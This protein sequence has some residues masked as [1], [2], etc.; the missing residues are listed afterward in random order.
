M[1]KYILG[2][3]TKQAKMICE[4]LGL[5]S[6][7]LS[8]L[9]RYQPRKKDLPIFISAGGAFHG[10]SLIL[11]EKLHQAGREVEVKVIYDRH[12]DFNAVVKEL[13]KNVSPH[14]MLSSHYDSKKGK[15][16]SILVPT[17]KEI[18]PKNPAAE[19]LYKSYGEYST[20]ALSV[21]QMN[22][23]EQL[24]LLGIEEESQQAQIDFALKG[25]KSILGK[26]KAVRSSTG[27]VASADLNRA[28]EIRNKKVHISIDIDVIK[29]VQCVGQN[30]NGETGPSLEE[31]VNS[32]ENLVS[33][34]IL[35][36]VDLVGYYPTDLWNKKEGSDTE[37]LNIYRKLLEMIDP[38]M[39]VTEEKLV[40]NLS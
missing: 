38:A 23:L 33:N 31:L 12:A 40:V 26:I 28:K 32:V 21:Y 25:G 35:V 19:E 36:A 22:M 4:H 10:D 5:D 7:L 13:Y 29:D 2:N 6:R 15:Q 9:H 24:Y 8:S 27:L 39:K 20:H 11:S 34:N 37:G 18:D 17:P 3:E 14:F 16:G 1:L 30:W